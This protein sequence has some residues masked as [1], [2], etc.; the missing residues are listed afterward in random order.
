VSARQKLVQVL[1]LQERYGD[2]VQELVGL[3][4]ALG[5]S[6][7]GAQFLLAA[8]R[9]SIVQLA[10]T[11]RTVDIL[12][13]TGQLFSNAEVGRWALSEAKRLRNGLSR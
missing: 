8:A 7:Q 6:P 4:K 11:V 9:M 2:A 12:E 1:S 5:P 3:G 10:D 13:Y